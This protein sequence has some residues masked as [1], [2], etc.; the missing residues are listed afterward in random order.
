M[1]FNPSISMNEP[2]GLLGFLTQDLAGPERDAVIRAF[3]EYAEGDP[4]SQPVGMAVLL[5][6]CARKMNTL[7][8]VVRH[9]VGEMRHLVDEVTRLEKESLE[10]LTSENSSAR[11][12]NKQ[13]AAQV[14]EWLRTEVSRGVNLFKGQQQGV[15]EAWGEVVRNFGEALAQGQKIHFELKPIVESAEKVGRDFQSVQAGLKLHDDSSQRT[16]AAV[17][18]LKTIHAEN[19][20]QGQHTQ[21]LIRSLTKEARVNWLTAGYFAGLLL[22]VILPSPSWWWIDGLL[23]FIPAGLLQWL[24]RRSWQKET[25]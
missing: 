25:N 15:Q 3:Y 14:V 19:Q 13:E 4:R 23:I 2:D 11:S 5:T 6:A 20:K 16:L 21:A 9:Q 7:P 18:S 12:A 17:E 24:S 10:K 22:T 8:L 1:N